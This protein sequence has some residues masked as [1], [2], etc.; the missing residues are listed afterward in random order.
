MSL[1]IPIFIIRTKNYKIYPILLFILRL[2]ISNN[3]FTQIYR[4][5]SI[6][7]GLQHFL[8]SWQTSE[9][10]VAQFPFV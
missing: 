10:V 4:I 9:D 7:P 6:H 8:M 3:V 1:N 2:N 5:F